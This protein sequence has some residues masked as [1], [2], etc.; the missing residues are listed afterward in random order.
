MWAKAGATFP[1]PA[2]Y[3]AAQ[4]RVRE[5][6]LLKHLPATYTAAQKPTTSPHPKGCLPATYTAAQ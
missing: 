3:T 2:T 5:L 4:I 1:L 6:H